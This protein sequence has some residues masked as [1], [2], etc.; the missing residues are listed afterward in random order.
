[1]DGEKGYRLVQLSAAERMKKIV[2]PFEEL[3]DAEKSLATQELGDLVEGTLFKFPE[4]VRVYDG[5]VDPDKVEAG[6]LLKSPSDDDGSYVTISVGSSSLKSDADKKDCEITI[7]RVDGDWR[8]REAYRYYVEDGDCARRFDAG[9]PFQKPRFEADDIPLS[10]YS[11]PWEMIARTEDAIQVLKNDLKNAQLEQDMGVNYQPVG[12]EEIAA[13]REL[14][15]SAE[16]D[17]IF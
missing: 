17:G 15:G 10:S 13:L 3:D 14:I 5:L 2:R 6:L 9:D 8:G 7:Q 1:M 4:A 11:N 12:T 16:P